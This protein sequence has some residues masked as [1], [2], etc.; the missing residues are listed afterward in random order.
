MKLALVTILLVFGINFMFQIYL[1]YNAIYCGDDNI[2]K[3]AP[4]GF[5]VG[6]FLTIEHECADRTRSDSDY[7]N[8]YPDNCRPSN[9]TPANM[10]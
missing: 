4:I 10:E 6:C 1:S 7:C 3:N 8:C 5:K 2:L 9:Y